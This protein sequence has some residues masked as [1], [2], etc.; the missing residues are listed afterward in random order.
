MV[1]TGGHKDGAEVDVNDAPDEAKAT[2]AAF[3]MDTTERVHGR[4]NLETWWR[5]WCTVELRSWD[6]SANITITG[7]TDT[8]EWHSCAWDGEVGRHQ[9]SLA[10]G[11]LAVDPV[12]HWS[13]HTQ[14]RTL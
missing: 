7:T 1:P 5:R 2:G 13:G 3:D 9:G 11:E 12:S 4:P 8:E 6:G 14:E 10:K